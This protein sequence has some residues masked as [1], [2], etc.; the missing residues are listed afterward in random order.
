MPRYTEYRTFPDIHSGTITHVAFNAGARLLASASLDGNL[1]ILNVKS[2]SLCYHYF[3]GNSILSLIWAD[4]ER[5]LCGL[6]DGSIT[7]LVINCETVCQLYTSV[8]V[9]L[10]LPLINVSIENS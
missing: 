10:G 9:S 1:F 5:V 6:K 4:A 7:C 8:W 2:S 3:T